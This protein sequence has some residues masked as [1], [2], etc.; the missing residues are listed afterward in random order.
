V[1][2]NYKY[3]DTLVPEVGRKI[4]KNRGDLSQLGIKRQE[5]LP[6]RKLPDMRRFR[7]MVRGSVLAQRDLIGELDGIRDRSDKVYEYTIWMRE[8]TT[9]DGQVFM[10]DTV[11]DANRQEL[12]DLLAPERLPSERVIF[13]DPEFHTVFGEFMAAGPLNCVQII[14]DAR[15][16]QLADPM[17]VEALRDIDLGD[18]NEGTIRV[19]ALDQDALLAATPDRILALQGVTDNWDPRTRMAFDYLQI[20]ALFRDAPL[21]AVQHEDFA[22]VRRKVIARLMSKG[23]DAPV[24][25]KEKVLGWVH[26]NKL[27]VEVREFDADGYDIE[28]RRETPDGGAPGGGHAE[29]RPTRDAIKA[30]VNR[31]WLAA[32]EGRYPGLTEHLQV[33]GVP[34]GKAV[35]KN[36]TQLERLR[37]EVADYLIEHEPRAPSGDDEANGKVINLGVDEEALD[38]VRDFCLYA[39]GCAQSGEN[40]NQL[41]TDFAFSR[42]LIYRHRLFED[43]GEVQAFLQAKPFELTEELFNTFIDLMLKPESI[44]ASVFTA[45]ISFKKAGHHASTFNLDNTLVKINGALGDPISLPVAQTRLKGSTYHG[46][47]PASMRLL[48]AYVMHRS[49]E[50]KMSGAIMLRMFPNPPGYAAIC[51]LEIYIDALE[52]TGFFKYMD[53]QKEYVGYKKSME[54]VRGVMH[55]CAPYSR[56]LYG[57]VEQDPEVERNNALRLV[58]YAAALQNVMPGSTLRMSPA[59][60]KQAANAAA[61]MIGAALDVEAF[62]SAYRRF[63][64]QLVE[65]QMTRSYAAKTGQKLVTNQ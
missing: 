28:D 39:I 27:K 54:V 55:F 52:Q 4:K 65:G 12:Q 30:M 51:N 40:S 32:N 17:L 19:V 23:F 42:L 7:F 49:A 1:D 53:R 61:N 57:R 18:Y 3:S 60:V 58:A 25:F 62:V 15:T 21:L 56:Y 59:L 16:L 24:W 50:D 48:I 13:D 20:R 63:F 11:T 35:D 29:D 45:C 34:R 22:G 47:H 44:Y 31:A 43:G 41:V 5:F 37:N 10:H 36:A 26:Y 8:R 6:A 14:N 46:S 64:R 38:M 9:L 33:R 2:L